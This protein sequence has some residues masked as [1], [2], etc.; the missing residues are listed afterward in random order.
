MSTV[1]TSAVILSV[2]I[3]CADWHYAAASKIL[4]SAVMQAMVA[5]RT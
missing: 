3:R 5:L 1:I 2:I 4:M